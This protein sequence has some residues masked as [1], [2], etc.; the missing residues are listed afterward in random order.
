MAA[1]SDLAEQTPTAPSTAHV[2]AP[3]PGPAAHEPDEPD[4]PWYESTVRDAGHQDA[5][6]ATELARLRRQYSRASTTTLHV[7]RPKP[8]TIL[9]RVGYAITQ[10]WR[11]HISITVDHVWCRDHLALER[12]FLGYLRTS[13]ALSMMGVTLAQLFRLQHNPQPN[14]DFG[15]YVLG[16]PLSVI[17]QCLAIYVLL[18]GAYRTWRLQNALVRGKAL[19]GGFEVVIIAVG[20]FLILLTFFALLVAVDI[21][22]E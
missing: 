15:Y 1:I 9:A 2:P 22:K 11:H 4:A 7:R 8:S 18:V 6:E 12:T 10:F 21:S 20:V 5:L 16:R 3:T 13:L 19:A 14:T 17:C